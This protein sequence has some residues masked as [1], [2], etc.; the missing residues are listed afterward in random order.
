MP[1]RE[2]VV[3]ISYDIP[4]IKGDKGYTDNKDDL[5]DDSKK[6]P[7]N[8]EAGRE[9]EKSESPPHVNHGSENILQEIVKISFQQNKLS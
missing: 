1:I 9:D 5:P 4:E 6:K 7:G 2:V 3:S 8:E